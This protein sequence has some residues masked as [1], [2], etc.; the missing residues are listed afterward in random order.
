[1]VRRAMLFSVLAVIACDRTTT[2]NDGASTVTIK[3]GSDRAVWDDYP[4]LICQ[5]GMGQWCTLDMQSCR[6]GIGTAI[7]AFDFGSNSIRSSGA[8]GALNIIAKLHWDVGDTDH[9]TNQVF[10]ESYLFSFMR[11]RKVE[12]GADTIEGIM[13]TTYY[14]EAFSVHMTCHPG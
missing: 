2:G 13:Q 1:M 5:Y 6:A 8:K 14:N 11:Q 4:K 10:A 7:L 12:I 9:D 3:K